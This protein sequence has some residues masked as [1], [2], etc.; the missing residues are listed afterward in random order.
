MLKRIVLRA[1][2]AALATSLTIGVAAVTAPAAFAQ[3]KAGLLPDFTELYERMGPAVVSIDVTQKA[4]RA[5]M[6]MKACCRSRR[7][8][9]VKIWKFKFRPARVWAMS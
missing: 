9:G 5:S 1:G 4:R 3:G 2:A 8:S 6:L 7:R